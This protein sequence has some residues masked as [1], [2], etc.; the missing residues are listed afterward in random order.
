VPPTRNLYGISFA[1]AN[2]TGFVARACEVLGQ[3]ERGLSGIAEVRAL[4]ASGA[5]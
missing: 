1:V 2:M 3:R 5:T 4:L